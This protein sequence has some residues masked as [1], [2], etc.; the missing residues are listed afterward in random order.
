MQM[1]RNK[2]KY[3]DT[4][5]HASKYLSFFICWAYTHTCVYVPKILLLPQKN[6]LYHHYHHNVLNCRCEWITQI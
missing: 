1:R 3:S 5:A 6:A 4:Y 2:C